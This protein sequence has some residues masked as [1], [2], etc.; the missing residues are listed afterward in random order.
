MD[1]LA[2]DFGQWLRKQRRQAGL[3]LRRLSA[4]VGLH[5]AYLSQLER[6]V[7][8]P[9]EPVIRRLAAFFG[10][11][12][13]D[14]LVLS[15]GRVPETLRQAL[16]QAPEQAQQAL[17]PLVNGTSLLSP[18]T[19]SRELALAAWRITAR[20]NPRLAIAAPAL[21]APGPALHERVSPS[22]S[23]GVTG[24]LSRM[25]LTSRPTGERERSQTSDGVKDTD[26]VEWL[27]VPG[28]RV[29]TSGLGAAV[30]TRPEAVVDGDL[31]TFYWSERAPQAG[32]FI[33]LDLGAEYPVAG[34]Q[35]FMGS[36][37]GEYARPADYVYSG[38]V[39]LSRDGRSW[40][41][42]GRLVGL[43]EG[44][45]R[46]TTLPARYIRLL[47]TADQVY[48]VQIREIRLLCPAGSSP[49]RPVWLCLDAARQAIARARA[50]LAAARRQFTPLDEERV[51][52]LLQQANVA[53]RQAQSLYQRASERPGLDTT[54]QNQ[55]RDQDVRK[56]A[57]QALVWA[58]QAQRWAMESR[59]V[60]VR[61]V[62]VDR[63]ALLAGPQ[64]L[65][66][67]L[68]RL[69]YVG[70][71]CLFGEVLSRGAA[72]FASD[73]APPDQQMKER[74]GELDPLAFLLDQGTRRG[75]KVVPW[76][77]VLCAGYDYEEGPLL[78]AHPEWAD[79]AVDGAI[80]APPPSGTAWLN[81]VLPEV[82]AFFQALATELWSRYGTADLHLDYL[83]YHEES[84]AAYGYAAR[85]R[86]TFEAS[87][88]T[89]FDAWRQEAVTSLLRS[90]AH[91]VRK[92]G[93][94]LSAAV[95]PDPVAAQQEVHQDWLAW[96]GEGADLAHSNPT[97]Q[98]PLL[99]YVVTTNYTADLEEFQH[100]IEAAAAATQGGRVLQGIASALLTPDELLQEVAAAAGSGALGVCLYS[101]STL[102]KGSLE[103]LGEGPFR[104]PALSPLAEPAESIRTLAQKWLNQWND[105]V[106]QGFVPEPLLPR[107]ESDV[108]QLASALA[109]LLQAN[110]PA[111]DQAVR[112]QQAVAAT[113][114]DFANKLEDELT[115]LPGKG[116]SKKAQAACRRLAHDA[117]FLSNVAN[118]MGGR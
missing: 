76:I 29:Q 45:W 63:S 93:G 79:Q 101:A 14:R 44:E 57:G 100:R 118:W 60:E 3:S 50:T 94:Q 26:G 22:E 53:V 17:Q 83:R 92:R 62:W 8:T 40:L 18:S 102:G 95:W 99:D 115:V 31:D 64:R 23:P 2:P 91:V 108:R 49:Q 78:A 84:I 11:P 38:I 70:V 69:A 98:H 86:Q 9:S 82:H 25:F 90:I 87:G 19:A 117:R 113:M 66:Q 88:S 46:F 112:S 85:A 77:W 81:P 97:D 51:T 34:V 75:M 109:T 6:G 47:V 24:E 73:I 20:R 32:D 15:A 114:A 5:F 68:D 30:G 16:S 80:V 35:L 96:L 105:R 55:A 12:Q 28:M 74:W 27:V 48:W 13:P 1:G 103:A 111:A 37:T 61:A 104:S 7:A 110:G 107:L 10:D 54:D 72:A 4:E 106:R 43:P 42:V 59:P 116:L 65:C 71:N 58:R 56:A 41:T 52:R 36:F 89:D 39:Q 67:L 33:A 21:L